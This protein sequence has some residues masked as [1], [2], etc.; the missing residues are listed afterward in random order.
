MPVIP[1]NRDADCGGNPV[2]TL[3]YASQLDVKT[4]RNIG[5]ANGRHRRSVR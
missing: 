4:R 2:E 5:G 1:R 3:P